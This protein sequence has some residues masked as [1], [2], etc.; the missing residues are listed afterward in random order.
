MIFSTCFIR[1]SAI[2]AL[3]IIF[4]ALS[5]QKSYAQDSQNE[6]SYQSF[7]SKNQQFDPD[8][9]ELYNDNLDLKHHKKFGFGTSLSGASGLVGLHT[10]LNLDP[11]NALVIA[12]GS[13]PSYGTFNLNWKYNFQGNYLS[14]Y[15][16]VGY[17]K[18]F[19]ASGTSGSAQQSDVLSRIFSAK[20]LKAGRFDA[21][22]LVSSIGVE[23]NQLEGELSGV[24]FYGEFVLLTEMKTAS[25]IPTG[26]VGM[27]YFY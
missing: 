4:A 20:D 6:D 16:K 12:L 10:E 5:P 7:F 17:S 14:S 27:T 18:W 3:I 2:L 26:A 23:Y 8:G 11:Q 21:D 1:S 15:T 9:T 13:G 22:F 25:L 24:N 19:S